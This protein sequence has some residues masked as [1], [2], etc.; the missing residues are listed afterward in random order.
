MRQ[1]RAPSQGLALAAQDSRTLAQLHTLSLCHSQPPL[2]QS[3]NHRLQELAALEESG[4][5][6]GYRASRLEQLQSDAAMLICNLQGVGAEGASQDTGVGLFA[7]AAALN[8]SCRPNCHP[9]TMGAPRW[10]PDGLSAHLAALAAALPALSA[11]SFHLAW[12]V[13]QGTCSAKQG[14]ELQGATRPITTS[15]QYAAAR[16]QPLPGVASRELCLCRTTPAAGQTM[17]VR[18]IVD[19]PAGAQLTVCHAQAYDPR[20]VRQAALLQVGTC[21]GPPWRVGLSCATAGAHL[22]A[23]FTCAV[24]RAETRG[25]RWTHQARGACH[26]L[27]YTLHPRTFCRMQERGIKCACERCSEPLAKSTDRYLEGVWCL[28]CTT[29]VLLAVP[30]GTPEAEAAAVVYEEQVRGLVMTS[31]VW[32]RLSWLPTPEVG[33]CRL[34][35]R[36]FADR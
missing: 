30:P 21:T 2:N 36:H 7:A 10:L 26:T 25:M 19:V 23:G 32:G 27:I 14:S 12:L 20:P 33:H 5:L 1:C 22:R 11:L 24:E 13:P 18:T 31:D 16:S 3:I 35:G 29:D 15:Q 34:R 8:H 9:V 6:P 28:N 17:Y 4:A